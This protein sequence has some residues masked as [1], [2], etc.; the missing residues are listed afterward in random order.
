MQQ[1]SIEI[2]YPATHSELIKR[3]HQKNQSRP[4]PLI[5]HYKEGGFNTLH[6]DLY[7]E[8]YFP[9]QVVFALTQHGK[10]YEGGQ[11]VLTEQI[12]RAQSKAQVIQP[13]QGDAVIFS[14]NFRPVAGSRGYYRAI[15]KHGVS[16]VTSGE[17]V[18]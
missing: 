7:G 18:G 6:Q 8:I 9:F 10:D 17:A 4:I 5:L 13:N 14:T 1:L 16:E 2:N 15:I 12:P 11:L 3:C